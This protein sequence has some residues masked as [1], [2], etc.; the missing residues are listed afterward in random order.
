MCV[1][2]KNVEVG[3]SLETAQKK[4]QEFISYQAKAIDGEF[5]AQGPKPGQ[6]AFYCEVE[7]C[8]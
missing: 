4:L 2:V 6:P 3:V 8:K 7:G 1:V 5:T